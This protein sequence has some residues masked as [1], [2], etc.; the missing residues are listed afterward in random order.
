VTP[1]YFSTLG[2]P[3]VRGRAFAPQDSA[4]SV[5][6]ALIDEAFAQTHFPGEN[7]IGQ[8]LDIGN[9]TDGAEIVGIVGNVSY[10]GLDELPSPTMYMPVTQDAFGTMWVMVRTAADPNSL[11][12]SVRQVVRDLD[13]S[14]PVS[15]MSPLDEVVSE[16]VAQQRFSMLLI[17]MFGMVA[18]VLSAVGLY[19]V[20]AYSVSLRTREIGLRMAIG[21]MPGDVLKMVVGDGM[22]L[23]AMGVVIGTVA[24]FVLSR[25]VASMLFEV[26]VSDP[27]SYSG[28]ALVL[29]LVAALACYIPARRAMRVDPMVTLQQ[30]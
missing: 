9:G 30:D 6:V 25:F 5:P 22:K 19:G 15:L 14:L 7:P 13:A 20:V 3:V 23:A 21:A 10:S 28:T 2:I 11:G 4:T 26:E 8:R 16:S 27:V 12:A 1:D 24:A 29:L 17:A 18:L